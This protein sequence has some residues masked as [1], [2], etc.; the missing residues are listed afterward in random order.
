MSECGRGTYGLGCIHNCS[1]HCLN[2]G[3]VT[4]QLVDVTKAVGR[5]IQECYV[6]QVWYLNTIFVDYVLNIDTCQPC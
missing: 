6:K 2:N 5:D 1:G 3:T 4:E